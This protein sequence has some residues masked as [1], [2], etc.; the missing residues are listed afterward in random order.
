MLCIIPDSFKD[1][2][3]PLKIMACQYQIQGGVEYHRADNHEA[4]MPSCILFVFFK[5]MRMVT[6]R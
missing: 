2:L 4:H 3:I 6:S 5:M 1:I